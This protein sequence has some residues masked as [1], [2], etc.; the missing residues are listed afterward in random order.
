VSREGDPTV[1]PSRDAVARIFARLTAD[2]DDLRAELDVC[3]R[4]LATL[5]RMIEEQTT[6]PRTSPATP[7]EPDASAMA[8]RLAEEALATAQ[9]A[10]E[11]ARRRN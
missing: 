7:A 2:R 3:Q 5:E 9:F 1:A 10:L 8:L 6:S 11:Q 4:R